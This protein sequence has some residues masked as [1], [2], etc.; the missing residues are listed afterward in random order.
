M[1]SQELIKKIQAI[2]T[3]EDLIGA[4]LAVD[5]FAKTADAMELKPVLY[6]LSRKI[7]A[8]INLLAAMQ[9]N[10]PTRMN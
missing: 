3:S 4:A 5:T 8:Y 1:T 10:Q 7:K 9:V 2:Q 6:A